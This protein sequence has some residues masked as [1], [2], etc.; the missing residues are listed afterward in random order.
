VKDLPPPKPDYQI[1]E[2][3]NRF[4]FHSVNDVQSPTAA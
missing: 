3:D 4:W 2:F 1:F